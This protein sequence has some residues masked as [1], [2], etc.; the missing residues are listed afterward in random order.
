MFLLNSKK[1]YHKV[2]ALNKSSQL[3]NLLTNKDTAMQL[4]TKLKRVVLVSLDWLLIV[5]PL[6]IK[7]KC[8]P[9]LLY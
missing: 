5:I 1:L 9:G 2:I 6:S 4:T 3:Q 7:G 8:Y